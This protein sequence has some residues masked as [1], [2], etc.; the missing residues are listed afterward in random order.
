M[1]FGNIFGILVII[2]DVWAVINIV[3][4]TVSVGHK[5]FWVL[6]VSML[7]MVGLLFWYFAGPRKA[8]N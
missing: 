6:L 3:Q 5:I 1:G 2:G 8:G 4:S 7:P